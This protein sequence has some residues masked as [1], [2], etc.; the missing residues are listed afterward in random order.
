MIRVNIGREMTWL[1]DSDL[2][3]YDVIVPA[4]VLEGLTKRTTSM[5]AK[6]E[7]PYVIDP[8]TYVFGLNVEHIVEKRWFSKLMGIY[9]LDGMMNDPN[10]F[11]LLP[12]L[13]VDE[14]IQSTNNLKELVEN[15]TN[16]Q[17]TRIRE[18]YDEINEFEEFDEEQGRNTL[19]LKPKWI[20][21]PYFFVNA[22]RRDWRPVNINSVKLAVENKNSNEKI[23][24]AIMMDR[25][26]L[27][28][29]KDIDEMVAEYDID[30]VDGYMVW[31]AD[32][33][34]NSA[35]LQDLSYFQEFIGKLADHKKPIY[36]MYGGLFSLL[37]EDKG[38]AGT[39]HSICYGE[40]KNPFAI[41][42]G[43]S[44]IRFYQ[45]HLYSK[46]P[47]TR[48][49]EIENELELERC[50][51]QYCD[52]LRDENNTDGKLELT[53]KHFL[54]NRIEEVEE[55]NL[56]G[57]ARFLKKLMAANQDATQKDQTRAYLNLYERF[58]LWNETINSSF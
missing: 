49:D 20:I 51:C 41:G 37:L 55:I 14:N 33:D 11:E 32:M 5:L 27:P 56:H 12:N 45:T 4:N 30:G 54:L 46:V 43:G 40:H 36:N 47:F 21:P 19:D 35:K 8:H 48:M 25:E 39:S 15:V 1:E 3:N 7:R 13:L 6:L 29:A 22:S 57:T 16:Y 17:R 31:C 38:M 26:M 18:T 44:I 58:S 42:G 10:D 23:F 53:G 34:E 52:I 24:A 9:G 28:H 50:T 2:G